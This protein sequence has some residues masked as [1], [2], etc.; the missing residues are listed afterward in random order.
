MR[1]FEELKEEQKKLMPVMRG[2]EWDL[3]L[4]VNWIY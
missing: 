3:M 2:I 4:V 1:N